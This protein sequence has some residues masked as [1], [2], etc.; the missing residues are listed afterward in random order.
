[1]QMSHSVFS[2]MFGLEQ[3]GPDFS[4]SMVLSPRCDGLKA[5]AVCQ[6][7]AGRK[8]VEQYCNEAKT[9][10]AAA[11]TEDRSCKLGGQIKSETG[12]DDLIDEVIA[13]RSKVYAYRTTKGKIGKRCKGVTGATQDKDLDWDTYKQC[14]LTTKAVPTTNVQFE[15]RAFSIRTAEITKP[16]LSANDGKRRILEDGIHT[17][18]WDDQDDMA[19]NVGAEEE[20]QQQQSRHCQLL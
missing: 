9:I 1:M 13:L 7:E 11:A 10:S 5:L 16:S 15:R 4:S 18:A 19:Q 6:T 14:L 17:R 12:T 3:S 8:E 2:Q 20:Q